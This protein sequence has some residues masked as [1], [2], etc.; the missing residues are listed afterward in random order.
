[1]S[2][3][4]AAVVGAGLA[5]RLLAIS[6]ARK[7][8]QI[9]VFEK[10][11][12]SGRDTCSYTGAGMIAPYCEQ[13]SAEPVICE[14]GLRSLEIWPEFLPS[15]PKPVFYQNDGSLVVAHP[16]DAD[17]LNRLQREVEYRDFDEPVMQVLDSTG[18]GEIEPELLGRFHRGLFFPNEAQLDNWQLLDSTL[19]AMK[20]LEIDC[21]FHTK[22]DVLK[23]G[24]IEYNGKTEAY[25]LVF[26]TRGLGAEEDLKDLRGVRGEL[27]HVIAPDVKLSRPVRM[28][29]PRYPL[30]IVPREEDRYV[31]G[32]TK[33]ESNDLSD[34]S[35]RGIL[36]LL[37]A[38]YALHPG[39]A[40]ARILETSTHCR[41]AWADNL[42]YV[43]FTDGLVRLNG[44]YRHGFLIAPALVE[45]VV[46]QVTGEAI[47]GPVADIVRFN[48]KRQG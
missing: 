11:D 12:D 44:M 9:T 23:A 33:I 1:M 15:L 43:D 32:A 39:F 29:H 24:E 3:T 16:N 28:M 7:G 41:P 47:Q 17:E 22:V 5:G 19:E 31:I 45:A 36:E 10:D 18:I 6:L 21:R 38:A 27:V 42:P 13:E 4:K 26:D 8:W 37:S 46:A 2:A 25:D 34:I 48:G 40:E 35:V 30:Y 20:K 14:I